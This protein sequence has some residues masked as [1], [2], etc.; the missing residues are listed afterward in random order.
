MA[1]RPRAVGFS[2]F[3]V[4]AGAFQA[5]PMRHGGDYVGGF[6]LGGRGPTSRRWSR[7]ARLGVVVFDVESGAPLTFNREARRIGASR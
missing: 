5:T 7:P 4:P 6:F 1:R 2:A 3:P